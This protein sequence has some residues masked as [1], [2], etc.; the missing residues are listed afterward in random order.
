MKFDLK[1]KIFG[2]GIVLA[3]RQYLACLSCR[4]AYKDFVVCLQDN[5]HM[6][7]S[8]KLVGDQLKLHI[9]TS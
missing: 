2:T 1:G 6:L 5:A 7:F 3:K 9:D 4:A 8:M